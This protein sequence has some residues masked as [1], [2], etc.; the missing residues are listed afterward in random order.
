MG[1]SET[2]MTVTTEP[3]HQVGR[4]HVFFII[5]LTPSIMPEKELAFKRLLRYYKKKEGRKTGDG[6]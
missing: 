5:I 4:N 2:Y 1:P 6:K 3:G